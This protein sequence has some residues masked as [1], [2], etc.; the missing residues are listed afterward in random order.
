MR[1]GLPTPDCC[2]RR[3]KIAAMTETSSQVA[4]AQS[5]TFT[6][7]GVR[8]GFIT[9]Q[10]LALGS[11]M[12][13]MT[14]GIL[15]LGSGLSVVEAVFMSLTIY[16]GSA[17]T[18]AVGA[19]SVGAGIY[20]TV[21][22]VVLLNARYVLYGATLRPWLSGT[23]TFKAY[24]ALYLLGDG[25]WV[26]CMKARAAGESDAGFVLGSGLA[27]FFPWMAGTLVGAL[28]GGWIPNPRALALDF[29]LVA[30]CAAMMA[31]MLR[32]R[33]NYLAATAA[34]V[35]ALLADRFFSAG[36]PIVAAGATGILTAYCC[37]PRPSDGIA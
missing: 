36:W 29:F 4:Q 6:S 15:A 25:N 28:T 22:T 20:A 3:S 27:M 12:Y 30:F 17:Q 33:P 5:T 23:T 2:W 7:V 14:F 8:R 24:S 18:A 13:G 9:S 26:V 34:L 16:S 21:A 35:A 31:G 11:L 37:K 10:P 1:I 32:A 19:I